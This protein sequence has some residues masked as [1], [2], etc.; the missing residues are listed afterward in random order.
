METFRHTYG[1]KFHWNYQN[2]SYFMYR[3]LYIYC[4]VFTIFI[5]PSSTHH[6]LDILSKIINIF[7][8]LLPTYL[9]TLFVL[10]HPYIQNHSFLPLTS[11]HV[12][13]LLIHAF[14]SFISTFNLK[15]Y[16][17]NEDYGNYVF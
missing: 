7:Y 15:Y 11:H 13:S 10:F 8:F 2:T 12:C 5:L 6:L 17:R 3:N 16:L 14:V 4:Q 1:A 9:Y